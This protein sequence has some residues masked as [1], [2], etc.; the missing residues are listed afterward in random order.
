MA[1]ESEAD[2][3]QRL[4]EL[5]TRNRW[6]IADVSRMTGLA[7]STISKV[8]NGH[9]SLTYDKLQQ[10]ARGLS[11]DLS[12]LFT[13]A[14]RPEAPTLGASRRS[15]GRAGDGVL[16]QAGSYEWRFLN[17]DLVPKQMVP[18]VGI[19]SARTLEEFGPLIKHEGEEFLF[20]LEG[21]IEVHTQFY[22]PVVLK[23]GDHLYIDSRMGH[24]YL[25]ASDA[26]CRVMVV[27]TGTT[28][29]LEQAVAIKP[30]TRLE[31]RRAPGRPKGR[32]AESKG[33]ALSTKVA[34]P[35]K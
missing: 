28:D 31:D 24:A 16:L 34:R 23:A 32:K 35:R 27:C 13:D 29:E 12:E 18:I 33:G 15:V 4:R 21:A 8:E 9:M 30:E 10:L 19:A 5:R 17:A 3:G 14:K 2:L 7:T 22:A 25:A 1:P 26:T 6:R 11:L 20:V